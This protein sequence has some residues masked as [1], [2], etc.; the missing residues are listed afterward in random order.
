MFAVYQSK[1]AGICPLT[2]TLSLPM[3]RMNVR[4]SHIS[5][6]L[7][8]LYGSQWEH[9]EALGWHEGGF[10]FYFPHEIDATELDVKRGLTCFKAT[11]MWS[12]VNNS[13]EVTLG[14]LVNELIYQRA[15][16][17]HTDEVMRERLIKL[18]RIPGMVAEKRKVLA[19]L[20]QEISGEELANRLAQKKGK[21][22]LFHYGLRVES[23]GWSTIVK[24]ALSVSSV[25][26]SLEK[27]A[28]TI[29]P[30]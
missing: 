14:A 11:V 6:G 28:D 30:K 27:W 17:L 18:I 24:N 13:D 22:P 10:N 12:S 20:G 5:I 3:S 16:A 1:Y 23:E 4:H 9:I 26:V 19:S 15:Q 7:R 25:V 2:A 29:T 8:F 21:H